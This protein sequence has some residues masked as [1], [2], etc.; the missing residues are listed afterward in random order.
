MTENAKLSERERLEELRGS[1]SNAV[2]AAEVAL[3]SQALLQRALDWLEEV[4][5]QLEEHEDL[6]QNDESDEPL[7]NEEVENILMWAEDFSTCVNEGDDVEDDCAPDGLTDEAI[8]AHNHLLANSLDPV[9]KT[10]WELYHA[11]IRAA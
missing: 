2:E 1:V 6:L 3:E 11:S 9:R 5:A 4:K 10:G 7:S 8:S